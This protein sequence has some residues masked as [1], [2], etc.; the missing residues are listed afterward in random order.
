MKN[1]NAVHDTIRVQKEIL[2]ALIELAPPT[3]ILIVYKFIL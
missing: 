1:P 3:D 2:D